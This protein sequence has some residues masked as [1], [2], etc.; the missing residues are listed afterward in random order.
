MK[1]I[2]KDGNGIVDAIQY[3]G[4]NKYDV[5]EWAM[6]RHG[7]S[8]VEYLRRENGDEYLVIYHRDTKLYV[9]QTYWVLKAAHG[10]D[11]LTDNEFQRLYM[12]DKANEKISKQLELAMKYLNHADSIGEA[13]IL[14][15]RS[16]L[17][18]IR[19]LETQSVKP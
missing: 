1:Y 2:S 10:L 6:Q 3:D 16:T 18:E 9:F 17:S 11:W 8:S 7:A 15:L 13:S 4:E 14:K 19:K 12:T 5:T